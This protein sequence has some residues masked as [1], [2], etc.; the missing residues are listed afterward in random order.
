MSLNTEHLKR[1]TAT[2][3]QS[4]VLFNKTE[5]D[6]LEN[7]IF[8]NAIVKSYELVLEMSGKLLKK[9]LKPFFASSKE[10][11]QLV[12]KDIFRAASQHGLLSPDEV[13]R[14]FKYRDNRNNTAHDYG[15]GFAQE[16]L[17]LIAPFIK[18]AKH[19]AE[20]LDHANA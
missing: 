19:L 4:I 6:S 7:E 11:D 14:W 18:D 5:P 1:C 12:F 3:E 10:V 2:L 9:V 16:T 13:K 8:R 20:V 15:V 17:L